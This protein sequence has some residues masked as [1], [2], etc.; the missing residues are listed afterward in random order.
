VGDDL[1]ADGMVK[2]E[3]KA[4]IDLL[5]NQIDGLNSQLEE[6]H[7]IHAQL[8]SANRV[9]YIVDSIVFKLKSDV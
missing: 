5:R 4:E 2:E 9:S 3:L 1:L 8:R 6:A 7:Q